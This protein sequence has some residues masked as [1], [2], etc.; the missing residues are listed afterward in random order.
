M[1]GLYEVYPLIFGCVLKKTSFT[2][3]TFTE[4]RR[5]SDK[6]IDL[7]F[8]CIAR[9]SRLVNLSN[10]EINFLFFG[11]LIEIFIGKINFILFFNAFRPSKVV[12][13]KFKDK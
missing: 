5:N 7:S 3:I 1:F 2:K 8:D 10:S 11:N 4:R 12:L 13:V 9:Q 6:L